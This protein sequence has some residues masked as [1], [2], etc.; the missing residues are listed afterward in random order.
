MTRESSHISH[1]ELPPI[2]L[3]AKHNFP[4]LL[5]QH[6]KCQVRHILSCISNTASN[7]S[8]EEN[9]GTHVHVEQDD[10][11]DRLGQADTTQLR[12]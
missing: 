7:V 1:T 8:S 5:L 3:E 6:W 9:D 11:L 12:E 4:H 2:A 10:V